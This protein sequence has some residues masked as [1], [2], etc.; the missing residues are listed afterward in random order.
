MSAKT[1][2]Q[3]QSKRVEKARK[4][5]ILAFS[6]VGSRVFPYRGSLDCLVQTVRLEGVHSLFRGMGGL[7]VTSLPRQVRICYKK[8]TV[9]YCEDWK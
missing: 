2:L 7:A 9:W 6:V 4:L 3:F 1:N 5:H 8:R